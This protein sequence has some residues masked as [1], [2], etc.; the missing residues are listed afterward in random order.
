[1]DCLQAIAQGH[2]VTL[3]RILALAWSGIVINVP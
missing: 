2:C 1:M 3:L